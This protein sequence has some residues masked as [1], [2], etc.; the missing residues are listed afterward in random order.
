VPPRVS[1]KQAGPSIFEKH[2]RARRAYWQYL[3]ITAKSADYGC[4]SSEMGHNNGDELTQL[5]IHRKAAL[6]WCLILKL[7]DVINSIIRK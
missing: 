1:H 5:T 2:E 6:A 4:H 3:R 7:F